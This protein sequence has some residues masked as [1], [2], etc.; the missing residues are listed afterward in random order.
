MIPPATTMK[1]TL[2]SDLTSPDEKR[3][4][5]LPWSS[6]SRAS[7]FDPVL[8]RVA[9]TWT[10]A[11][12]VPVAVALVTIV[13]LAIVHLATCLASRDAILDASVRLPS[14][15]R[16]TV[17]EYP[18]PIYATL[19]RLRGVQPVPESASDGDRATAAKSTTVWTRMLPPLL[20]PRV[21]GTV[22]HAEARAHL[23]AHLERI[24]FH[25]ELDHFNATTP[26]GVKPMANVIATWDRHAPKRLVLAAHYDSKYFSRWEFIGAID[27][28]ASCAILLDVAETV[29]PALHATKT[30]TTLQLVF[31]D[32]EEAWGPISESNS[33]YGSR[34]LAATWAATSA[35]SGGTDT[36][37]DTITTFVLLDLL[38]SRS[39]PIRNQ[40]LETT[41]QFQSLIDVEA[42]LRA[43][44]FLT[45]AANTSMTYFEE[46]FERRHIQDDQIPFWQA[47]VPVVHAIPLPFPDVWHTVRDTVD[48]LDPVIVVDLARVFAA[49][50]VEELRLQAPAPVARDVT[51]RMWREWSMLGRK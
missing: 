5:S 20:V 36:M 18:E 45:A 13:T 29:A 25:V 27:A 12:F 11:R 15:V 28:A 37:L 7:A 40:H 51:A 49:F 31:F 46:T 33:I 3:A 41:A 9:A 50:A 44:R 19:L 34:H 8:A 30:D 17:T 47:G 1:P 24:G 21:P 32:G 14:T 16:N 39:A 2:V 4:R 10:W 22:T 42:D 35:P 38:G 26:M 43:R 6:P 48:A 23:A